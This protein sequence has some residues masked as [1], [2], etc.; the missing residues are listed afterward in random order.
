M[1][2]LDYISENEDKFLQERWG[3]IGWILFIGFSAIIGIIIG[4]II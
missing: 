4:M 2:N 3:V 1:K